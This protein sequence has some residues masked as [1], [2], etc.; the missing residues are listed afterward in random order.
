MSTACHPGRLT[1][2]CFDERFLE[3]SWHWLQDPEVKRLTMTPDF[4]REQQRRWFDRLP[5][6]KDYQIWGLLCESSPIGA[7]GLKHIAGEE[8]EYWGYIGEREYWGAGLG[9]E[10][11]K[12]I[13]GKAKSLGLRELYLSVHK[14][15][16]R[17][18]GLYSKAGFRTVGEIAGV[19]KMRIS[20][21]DTNVR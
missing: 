19:L 14:D 7:V 18:V 21:A 5:E 1:F 17:A 10:M 3:R 9:A 2:S 6:M 12:F 13:L 11:M 20:V 15:N 4:T 16:V 8:A